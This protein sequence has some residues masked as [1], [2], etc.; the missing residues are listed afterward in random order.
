VVPETP[1]ALEFAEAYR[2]V[3]LMFGVAGSV[4]GRRRAIGLPAVPVVEVDNFTFEL[5]RLGHL[6]ESLRDYCQ[7]YGEG[8]RAEAGLSAKDTSLDQML[9]KALWE[10]QPLLAHNVV[11]LDVIRTW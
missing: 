1:Q 4:S 9:L 2:I 10:L 8:L 6:A 3:P 7:L 11:Y 5:W